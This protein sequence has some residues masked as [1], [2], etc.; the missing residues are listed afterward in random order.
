MELILLGTGAA[1][2]REP[3]ENG[4]CRGYASTLL[5]GHILL[6]CTDHSLQ[7]MDAMGIQW[8]DVTD[9]FFTHSHDDHCAAGAVRTLAE[10]RRREGRSP[11]RI[12]GEKAWIGQV[13]APE[14]ACWQVTEL[15]AGREEC[16][17]DYRILPLAANHRTE[18]EA[19]TAL[20]YLIQGGERTI[21]YA[22]DGAWMLTQTW[23]ALRRHAIDAW[24]VDCTIGDGHEGDYRIFE[25][26]SLSMVKAMARTLMA[27]TPYGP[28]VLKEGAP[29][30][31]SHLA[32]TLHPSQREQERLLEP[33]FAAAYDGMRLQIG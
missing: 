27:E 3:R 12:Y 17:G 10:A 7:K 25:H 14:D 21:L 9:L 5:D 28:P 20:S 29:I 19:E 30:V 24:I 6:D 22:L 33:P 31:L 1:D 26:N 32:K 18:R 11:L 4:E 16:C 15:R 2:W 13:F 8:S 23:A